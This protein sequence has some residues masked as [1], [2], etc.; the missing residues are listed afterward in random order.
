MLGNRTPFFSIFRG[1]FMAMQRSRLVVAIVLAAVAPAAAQPG[2]RVKDINPGRIDIPNLFLLGTPMKAMGSIVFFAYDDQVHGGELWKYDPANG[3]SQVLDICPGICA[4]F[5]RELT[6]LDGVLYFIAND[7]AH[8]RE[9]WRSDG[10]AAGTRLV[11]DINPGLGDGPTALF[12]DALHHVLYLAADD[13]VHGRELWKSDGTA[14]GTVLVKDINPGAG[15]SNPGFGAAGNGVVLF[16]ADDGLHGKEPWTTDGTGAG[17]SLLADINPGSGDSVYP[18]YS[19]VFGSGAVFLP[20]TSAPGTFLFAADDGV[21]GSEP[22]ASDGTPAGTRLVLDILPGT[23]SSLGFND[24]AAL[25]GSAYFGADDGVH[26]WELWKSDGTAGGTALVK[27]IYPGPTGSGVFE[28]T[29]FGGALYFRARHDS[30][31]FCELWKSDGTAAGTVLLASFD[32]AATL[33]ALPGFMG[34]APAGSALLFFA[35]DPQHGAELWKTDGTPAGTVLVDDIWPGPSSSMPFY[36]L[37]GFASDGVTGYFLASDPQGGLRLWRSDGTTAGTAAAQTPLGSTSSM[38]LF[39]GRFL[40]GDPP[41]GALAG[42]AC[43]GA[44]DASAQAQLWC[45]DGTAAGTTLV[46]QLGPPGDVAAQFAPLGS[47]LLFAGI[48]G[49]WATDGTPAGTKLLGGTGQADGLKAFQGKV[50]FV[51]SD[52]QHGAEL[53]RSD[54][55]AA[56]TGLLSNFGAYPSQL[57]PAGGSLFLEAGGGLWKTD[58][59][60]AGTGGVASFP[61]VPTRLID[62]GGTLFFF[63]DDGSH[64]RE[65]WKSDGTAAGTVM[66]KD[67]NPGA[68]SS[69]VAPWWTSYGETLMAALGGVLYFA[70]GDGAAGEELWRSDGTAAGTFLVKDI[71]PGAAGSQPRGLTAAG[72]KLFFVADDGVHGRE[73]WV[74]DG[75]AAGT[76]LLADI[77]PGAGSSVPQ[78][79]RAVGSRLVFNAFEPAHGRELW[80]SDGTPA[81][82]RLLQD[83]A[84]GPA[85]ASP[86]GFAVGGPYL[87]F[88]ATDGQTGWEPH[89][90]LLAALDG[91]GY[92]TVAPCRLFDSRGGPPLAAGVARTIAAAGACGIPPAAGAI[93]VNLTT[94]GATSAGHLASYAAGVI[95][96]AASTI[97]FR[98]GLV[99]SNNAVQALGGGA[100]V[101]VPHAAGGQVDLVVDV[102]GWFE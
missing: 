29:T 91:F 83:I 79:L 21:H 14:A 32:Q 40:G 44:S 72:G 13:G 100:F 43:F 80:V 86:M 55:T 11:K 92:H 6:A 41:F 17:T 18:F 10:S 39:N 7:G 20:Q 34:W 64:G 49:L 75:T 3:A 53:W 46:K 82:T 36:G 54:G 4:A 50:Y 60:T 88:G 93:A 95:E 90:L 23:T 65:L 77:V 26:G 58:G 81:G 16:S 22:W 69:D 63:A 70:A 38:P 102:A 56:G 45:S 84:P 62:V 61:S 89:A 24:L 35:A 78:A 59:T 30:T 68:G 87:F 76:R 51:N 57:T 28:V 31:T 48:G 12:A 101:V 8:G 98:P 15:D 5:P 33:A 37:G 27:D 97:N 42:G 96:P 71:N 2:F 66:V 9:L 73:P 1:C 94:S 25:G 52:P 19:S 85:P 99:R 74:S 47:S 67:I